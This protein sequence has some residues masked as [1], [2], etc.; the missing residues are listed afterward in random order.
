M[1][2]QAP[3]TSPGTPQAV[4]GAANGTEG[5]GAAG[6]EA[7][8]ALPPAAPIGGAS[9]PLVSL[10]GANAPEAALEVGE[11]GLVNTKRERR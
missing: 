10:P 5:I 11:E 7:G 3:L 8:G 6:G 9:H 2:S 4:P 1:A